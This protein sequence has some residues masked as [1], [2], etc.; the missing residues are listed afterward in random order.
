MSEQ[1][2]L[3]REQLSA[4]E[5]APALQEVLGGE[6]SAPLKSP[7]SS[8]W[9]PTWSKLFQ[10]FS[11]TFV[12]LHEDPD[13]EL[14]DQPLEIPSQAN[15]L[16]GQ[17]LQ[18]LN[19]S[20]LRDSTATYQ[21]VAD[22]I[23]DIS[24]AQRKYDICK[25]AEHSFTHYLKYTA[26]QEQ[27]IA[28]ADF[29]VD[30][31]NNPVMFTKH[32]G[33]GLNGQTTLSFH[34]ISINELTYPAG[35]IFMVERAG[36][37]TTDQSLYSDDFCNI[38]ELDSIEVIRP[39]RLSLFPIPSPQRPDAIKKLP[40]KSWKAKVKNKDAI[41]E[42]SDTPSLYEMRLLAAN[43]TSFCLGSTGQPDTL[44]VTA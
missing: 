20:L 28:S 33:S 17:F 29:Y 19:G 41:K 12:I 15:W 24:D 2:D 23:R 7:A 9:A 4:V 31:D 27:K 6:T 25:G 42:S 21:M 35:T 13:I 11:N 38:F 14:V 32:A 1:F 10:A 22:G 3:V 36:N 40:E 8:I 30:P 43:H 34:D 26:Y 44:E 5:V 37:D 16:G 18:L 39:L